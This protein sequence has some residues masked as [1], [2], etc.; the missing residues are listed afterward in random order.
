[1]NSKLMESTKRVVALA[2]A[3]DAAGRSGDWIDVS[4]GQALLV[5]V[6]ITQGHATPPAITFQQA[7]D[8]A[9]TGAKALTGNLKIWAN[10]D[11]DASDTLVAQTDAKTFTPSAALKNK[12]VFF[13][14]DPRS[15]LDINGGFKAV[16]VITGAS[17]AANITFADYTLDGLMFQGDPTAIPSVL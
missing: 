11:T 5:C 3:A 1:M 14:L 7:T 10:Q 12:Q 16:K 8:T 6:T 15:A 17:N 2:P 13:K 4:K 9:G